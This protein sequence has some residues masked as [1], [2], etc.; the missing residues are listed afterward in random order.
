M[1]ECDMQNI[2][3]LDKASGGDY[4]SVRNIYELATIS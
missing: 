2:M 4:E 3:Q 1:H